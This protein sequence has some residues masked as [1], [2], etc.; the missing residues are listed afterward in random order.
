MHRAWPVSLAVLALLCAGCG[1]SSPKTTSSGPG[2]TGAGPASSTSTMTAT[3]QQG[4]G[5]KGPEGI[6]LESGP[7][8]APASTSAPGTPVD[9]IQ[10]GATE[11]IAYHIHAHLQVYVEGQPRELPPG[12]GMVGAV[13]QQTAAGPFYGA[14]QCYYWLHVHAGDG[15]IHVESP[16]QNVYTLGNFFDIWR[17]PLGAAQVAGAKGPVTAF[18]NGRR[19]T[20]D[21][22]AIPLLPHAAIQLDVGQPVVPFQPVS[23]AGS[24]L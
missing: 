5:A 7:P 22:R 9:G 16:T 23:W 17:Q 10:C 6:L 24:G 13:A 4:A 15:V 18:V 21:P 12:I 1:S 20:K 8:L 19:W 11:Q 3:S 2:T 14:T